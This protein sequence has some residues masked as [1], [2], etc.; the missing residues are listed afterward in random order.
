M[1]SRP[2]AALLAAATLT[3]VCPLAAA[4]P[5]PK[6]APE[7]ANLNVFE[8]TWACEGQVPASPMGPGGAMTSTVVSRQDLGGFWRSGTVKSTGAGMPGTMEGMFHMT[9]DPGAKEYVLLWVDNM[10][11]WS[12]A[13]SPG[14]NGDTLVF[15]GEGKMG[16][17]KMVVRDTF[18]KAANGSLRHDWE[19]QIEGKWTPMGSESCKKGT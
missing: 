13:S 16:G 10:G 7:M 18:V 3:A 11:G 12:Q 8:G 15:T 9:Y 14:W 5:P 2:L 4:D 19:M 6:P 17:D 1:K